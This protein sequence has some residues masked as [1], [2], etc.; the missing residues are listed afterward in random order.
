MEAL[1]A[2][3]TRRS[4]RQFTAQTVP[5]ERVEALLRAAMSAPSASNQQPWEFIVVTD[6]ASLNHVAAIH[7]HCQMAK[8]AQVGILVCARSGRE[9]EPGYWPQ[10]CAA[11]IENL[12]IAARALGLGAVW[13]GI[14]PRAERVAAF[15]KAFGIPDDIT[16]VAMIPIGYP[17]EDPPPADRYDPARIH[18]DRW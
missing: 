2:I 5:D 10:D 16:P 6:R 17:A 4:I 14:H 12:L 9:A 18:R 8:M 11:A 13:T 3:R 15:R 7:P 1:E